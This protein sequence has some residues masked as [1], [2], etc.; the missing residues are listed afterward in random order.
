MVVFAQEDLNQRA[1]STGNSA[2]V[3]NSINSVSTT[4]LGLDFVDANIIVSS[5]NLFVLAWTI[6]YIILALVHFFNG[7]VFNSGGELASEKEGMRGIY[8][9]IRYAWSYVFTL[10]FFLGFTFISN[11]LPSFVLLAGLFMI[12]VYG[13]KLIYDIKW[14]MDLF[15]YFPWADSIAKSIRSLTNFKIPKK[16]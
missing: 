2:S 11:S 4:N 6:F 10:P 9:A 15:D 13:L 3:S 16:K 1:N 8:R 5:V 12:L 7:R 14:I